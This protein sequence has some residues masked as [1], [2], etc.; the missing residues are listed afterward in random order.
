MTEGIPDRK[1]GVERLAG[2]TGLLISF[3]V[4]GAIFTGLD[5]FPEMV[6]MQEDL[7]FLGENLERL[8][9][10][11]LVWFINSILI[12]LFGPLILMGFIPYGRSSAYLAAFLIT[13]TGIIYLFFAL[14]GF[15]LIHLVRDFMDIGEGEADFGVL[16]YHIMITKANL[17]L[18][19]Y[20]LAGIS[21][22]ILGLLI[23]RTGLIPKFIGWLAI[24]GGMI[25]GGM[26][27]VSTDNLLFTLGRLLFVISLIL[28][29]AIL[30][31][32]G[33]GEKEGKS[34]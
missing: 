22:L 2:I 23:I 17:Q 29:G 4:V 13:T 25:Y 8:R 9:I 26:G 16:A 34:A 5:I 30:L 1:R 33:P 7:A 6:N 31:L 18:A 21:S 10:N 19:A 15:N 27:W 3:L 28:L 32:R 12:I 11:T 24:A 14:Q 20:S